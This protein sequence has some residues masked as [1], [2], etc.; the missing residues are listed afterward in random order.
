MTTLVTKANKAQVGGAKILLAIV[1][2]F[3]VFSPTGIAKP[4]VYLGITARMVARRLMGVSDWTALAVFAAICP[5]HVK[6][7]RLC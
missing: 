7:P 5:T 4:P 3:A 6:P 1:V 2:F